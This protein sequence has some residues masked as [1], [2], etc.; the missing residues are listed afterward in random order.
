MAGLSLFSPPPTAS[1]ASPSSR[2]RGQEHVGLASVVVL[3]LKGVH[4]HIDV[5]RPGL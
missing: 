2:E 3:D 5:S 4:G 1:W